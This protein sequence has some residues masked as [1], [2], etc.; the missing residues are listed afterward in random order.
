M[1]TK[2]ILCFITML[3]C[4]VFTGTVSEASEFAITP[5]PMPGQQQEEYKTPE[6]IK[7]GIY[8]YEIMDEKEKKVALRY[9]DSVGEKLEI[10]SYID[11]YKVVTVGLPYNNDSIVT[12]WLYGEEKRDVILSGKESLKEL[13]IPEGVNYLGESAFEDCINLSKLNLPSNS[14]VFGAGV[15]INC[16]S[17]SRFAFRNY[18]KL[19]AG[20]LSTQG[21]IEEIVLLTSL[22]YDGESVPFGSNTFIKRI[23]I[24][25]TAWKYID[26]M[27]F[28]HEECI[29]E[30]VV[31][32]KLKK[33][34]FAEPYNRKGMTV[35][36][37]VVNHKNTKLAYVI[38]NNEKMEKIKFN[39][40][41]TVSGAK[42]I[43]FAKSHKAT[44]YVKQTGKKQVVKAKKVKKGYKATWKTV[45]T[46]VTTN[47]YKTKKK[48]WT[49][50]TKAIKTVYNVYGKKKKS[51]KYQFIKSTKKKQIVSKYKYVKVVPKGTW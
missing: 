32:A 40:I 44:Y 23:Y 47:K 15:F 36:K 48:K 7:S 5:T 46:T 25:Q 3:Y 51:G 42:A 2:S 29:E 14:I 20:A 27:T 49:K 31:D 17:L 30:I 50:S 39:S 6:K 41:Y 9:I 10:P 22:P 8:T 1:K 28:R 34:S 35:G 18:V 21:K 12:G 26:L 24:P 38:E 4:L 13:T 37:L 19:Y 45:K 33:M 11:G 43:S 16:K